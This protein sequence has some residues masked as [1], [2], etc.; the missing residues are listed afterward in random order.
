MIEASAKLKFIFFIDAVL[1]LLCAAGIISINQ[2]ASLPFELVNQDSFLSIQISKLNPYG[3]TAGDK[4]ISVDCLRSNTIEKTEFITDR[5][6]IGENILISVQTK[7]GIKTLSVTLTNYYSNFYLVSTILVALFFFII[8]LFVLFKKPEMQAAHVF[9][10]ASIGLSIMLC[11]TWSN[12]NTFD[13]L[14]KYFLRSILHVSYALTPAL[15][16][17]F[18]LIFPRDKTDKWRKLLLLNYLIA[19]ILVAINIY[20][21]VYTLSVFSDASIDNYLIVFNYLRVCLITNVSFSISILILAFLKEKGTVE[22]Q[23]LKWLLFGFI[24]GPLSLWSC[25]TILLLQT[26]I[27]KK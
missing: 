5:K 9:H 8:A 15:F 16:V 7:T 22:R 3:L 23:Q 25:F 20:V 19:L 21:F 24:I 10:W 13:F 2:K 12:L 27:Q 14:S 17:H 18:A 26:L 6:N 1:F 11:L 4:L